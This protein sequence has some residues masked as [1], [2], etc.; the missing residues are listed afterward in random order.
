MKADV[1]VEIMVGRAEKKAEKTE[2]KDRAE[3][4]HDHF[5][6]DVKCNIEGAI[7]SVLS[8][9][10]RSLHQQLSSSGRIQVFWNKDKDLPSIVGGPS[11]DFRRNVRYKIGGQSRGNRGRSGVIGTL[12]ERDKLWQYRVIGGPV[13]TLTR[14]CETSARGEEEH[15]RQGCVPAEVVCRPEATHTSPVPVVRKGP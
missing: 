15:A 1:N 4:R 13:R 2:M 8:D 14:G 6:Q 10:E 5:K 3:A 9:I 11:R 12:Y 7:N